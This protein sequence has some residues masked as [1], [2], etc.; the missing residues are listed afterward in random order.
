MTALERSPVP[1][2][3]AGTAVLLLMLTVVALTVPMNGTVEHFSQHLVLGLPLLLLLVLALGWWPRPAPEFAARLA[4]GVLVAGLAIAGVGVL[5]EAI[6]AF[7]FTANGYGRANALADLHDVAVLVWPLGLVLVMAGAI[8][9]A[10]V[11]LAARR[12]ASGS[13]MVTI[14]AV[15]AVV[16]AVAFVAGGLILGY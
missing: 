4:R 14:A 8:L 5:A 10:G 7:G 6:G 2:S 13:R 9:T 12:G 11:L 16:A 15:V 1:V 3:V